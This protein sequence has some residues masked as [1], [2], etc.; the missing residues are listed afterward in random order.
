MT[1]VLYENTS[2]LTHAKKSEISA[3]VGVTGIPTP[4]H[5]GAAKYFAEKGIEVS[6][7]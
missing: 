3:A 6:V 2:E 7:K 5:A 4:F 1:K